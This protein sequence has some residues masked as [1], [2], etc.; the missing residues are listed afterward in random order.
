MTKPGL[1]DNEASIAVLPFVDMSPEQDQEYFSDGIS[2]EILN[3][4]A[5]IPNLKVTS[6]SSSFALKGERL[7]LRDVAQRL[8]VAHILEGSVRKAGN[9]VR[10]TAQLIEAET[11]SHLWSET[12]DRE[13]DNIFQ[14][15][16]DLSAAIGLVL[17]D[18]LLGGQQQILSEERLAEADEVDPV[19]YLLYLQAMYLRENLDTVEDGLET[20]RLLLE[21]VEIDPGFANALAYLALATPTVSTYGLIP[22][23]EGGDLVMASATRALAIDQQNDAA[24]RAIAIH[25]G[26]FE[27]DFE[28]AIEEFLKALEINP[29]S[30]E[31]NS[32]LSTSYAYLG[33][34]D[35]AV[36]HLQRAMEL[37]PLSLG[38][39]RDEGDIASLA[40]DYELAEQKF[41]EFLAIRPETLNTQVALSIVLIMQGKAGEVLELFPGE[42]DD[43]FVLFKLALA[44]FDAGNMDEAD[45]LLNYFLE[46]AAI[47]GPYQIAELYCHRG[48]YEQ[49]IDWLELALERKDPGLLNI[50][51]SWFLEPV[52]EHSRFLELVGDMGL[53]QALQRQQALLERTRTATVFQ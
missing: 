1:V 19:A 11:D 42:Q 48:E 47:E 36:M 16:D 23:A 10:I 24:H 9:Q 41:R 8:G 46:T 53:T 4:L 26:S 29:N 2:E 40:R 49:C 20:R 25:R 31:V 44:H 43:Y 51:S 32:Q 18:K 38:N 30:A 13:L 34:H 33:D 14:I 6:R 28:G 17:E 5:K 45:E 15:Q 22:F 50:V 3:V 52:F 35:K 21:A 12:Y 39:L 7:D 27:M 37:D